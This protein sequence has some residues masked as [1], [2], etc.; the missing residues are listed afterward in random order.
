MDQEIQDAQAETMKLKEEVVKLEKDFSDKFYE[1]WLDAYR[2]KH[3]YPNLDWA[4]FDNLKSLITWNTNT[5]YL[6][7]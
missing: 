5:N 2:C 6:K 4:P 7:Y 1:C 3:S